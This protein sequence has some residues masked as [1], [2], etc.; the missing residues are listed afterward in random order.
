MVEWAFVRTEVLR[1]ALQ[2][3]GGIVV[4]G[5]TV[6]LTLSKLWTYFFSS[7]SKEKSAEGEDITVADA[8][9]RGVLLRSGALINA[10]TG[11]ENA[12]AATNAANAETENPMNAMSAANAANAMNAANALN[13]MNAMNVNDES[14]NYLSRPPP[15]PPPP[16]VEPLAPPKPRSLVTESSNVGAVGAGYPQVVMLHPMSGRGARAVNQNQVL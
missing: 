11:Y 4:Y 9:R 15:P 3:L 1:G 7:S 2:A 8:I 12:S 5:V 10:A 16:S 6:W 14:T 13:A